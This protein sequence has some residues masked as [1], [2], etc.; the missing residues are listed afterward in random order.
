MVEIDMETVEFHADQ[1][2][3]KLVFTKPNGLHRF[4]KKDTE[5]LDIWGTGTIVVQ[6]KNDFGEFRVTK[7]FRDLT[8][9]EITNKLEYYAK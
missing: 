5:A 3:Y 4:Q 8:Q 1:F 2:G 6:R 9:S 7:V